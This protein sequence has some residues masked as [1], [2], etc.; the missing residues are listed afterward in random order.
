L[1]KRT[2]KLYPGSLAHDDYVQIVA[3]LLQK[4]G[5]PAGPSAPSFE[6][7]TKSS[8]PFVFRAQ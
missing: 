6:A 7:A 3:S 4:N 5:Y 1:K 2:K 8:V